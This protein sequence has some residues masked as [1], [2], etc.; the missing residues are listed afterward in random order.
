MGATMSPEVG[1]ILQ[2]PFLAPL[3]QRARYLQS[4]RGFLETV[5][6]RI[7]SCAS[8]TSPHLLC[9]L[10]PQLASLRVVLAGVAP[11]DVAGGRVI[12]EGYDIRYAIQ[13]IGG[14]RLVVCA[15]FIKTCG[16]REGLQG[17][18]Y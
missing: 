6:R 12:S 1:H 11:N 18:I 5:A 13:T 4:R 17:S 7:P 15:Q 2:Y 16:T 10:N 14:R 3:L 9:A 8:T